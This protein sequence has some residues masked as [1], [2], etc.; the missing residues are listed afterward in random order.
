MTGRAAVHMFGATACTF[1]SPTTSSCWS[2]LRVSCRFVLPACSRPAHA[3]HR[4]WPRSRTNPT[5]G[6]WRKQSVSKRGHAPFECEAGFAA[7]QRQSRH[8]PA[9]Q[10]IIASPKVQTKKRHCCLGGGRGVMLR[11]T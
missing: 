11:C 8:A 10:W 1:F 2:W 6:P 7:L 9:H 3:L 5:P 4:Q